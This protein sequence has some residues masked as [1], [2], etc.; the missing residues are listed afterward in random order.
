M[1]VPLTS[2]WSALRERPAVL[3]LALVLLIA[4]GWALVGLPGARSA[5]VAMDEAVLLAFRSADDLAD[6]IGPA[7]VEEAMRDITALGGVTVTTF[8]LL[9]AV[10]FLA[11]AGR[12][13]TAFY[14]LLVI[15]SGIITAFL[16][17]SGFDRPRPDLVP[18]GSHVVTSSFPSGHAATAAVLYLTLGAALSRV[19]RLPSQRVLAMALAVVLTVAVGVSRVYLGVHYPTDV[20][21]G[22]LVGGGWAVGAWAV[23]R[24]LQRRGTLEPA[25]ADV[26]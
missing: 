3:V 10:G 1:P 26:D 18:H 22:W 9:V 20:L 6:P 24:A 2:L 4:G 17:K 7:V 21:A 15:G 13:R 5:I 23:E 25:P 12:A 11:L 16:L 8:L 19:L 14:L